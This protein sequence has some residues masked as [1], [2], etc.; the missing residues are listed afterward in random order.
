LS[1]SKAWD[2]TRAIIAR[3]GK[4][5]ATVGAALL[6]LP[7]VVAGVVSGE[8]A[9]ATSE[10]GAVEVLVILVTV[11]IGVVGQLAVAWLAIGPRVSVAESIRHGLSR[12]LP[13]IGAMLLVI[14]GLV[15]VFVII[16]AVLMAVGGIEPMADDPSPRDILIVLVAMLIPMLF[17]AVRLMPTLPVAAAETLGP[18]GILKRS[19][20]LTAGSFGRLA[21]FLLLFLIAAVIVALAIGAIGGVI[22]IMLLGSAA[23]F[24]FGA[25]VLALLV[26]LVQTALI[27]VYVL[28]LARIYVQLAGGR[29]AEAS[30]PHS[31]T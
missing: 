4:L 27:L 25:L 23:P 19:W 11:L 12:T 1:I 28:M 7:Q 29:P 17:V 31:G 9:E 3:D 26:G 18:I 8:G 15:V 6:L 2:E 5:L 14:L 13:F 24:S 20:A 16:A 30:V 22:A 21:G 10:P